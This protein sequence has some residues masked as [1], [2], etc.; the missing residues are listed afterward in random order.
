MTTSYAYESVSLD[1]VKQWFSDMQKEVH[2]LGPLL[3]PGYGS[4]TQNSEEGTSVEIESFLGE[5]LV[6]HG[7]RSVFFVRSFNFY[8]RLKFELTYIVFL[9]FP[10]ALPTGR[11]FRNTLTN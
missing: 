1:A 6:Q 11:Q 10:L 2:V 5:M 3:P 4:K 9:R 7:K 8:L